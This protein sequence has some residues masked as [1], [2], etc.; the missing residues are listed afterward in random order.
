M[1][2]FIGSE[3]AK[4]EAVRFVEGITLR[5]AT[6]ADDKK[7]I[8]KDWT[9]SRYIESITEG[10]ETVDDYDYHMLREAFVTRE[11]GET[12][13]AGNLTACVEKVEVFDDINVLSPEYMDRDMLL[14]MKVIDEEGNLLEGEK[15]YNR[16][17]SDCV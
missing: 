6:E 15:T 17:Y 14:Y 13:Q 9:W 4:E 10:Y 1:E 2:L 3:T 11:I 8:V 7:A 16:R 5:L 12:V